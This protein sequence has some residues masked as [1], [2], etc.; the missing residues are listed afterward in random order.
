[1]NMIQKLNDATRSPTQQL[2]IIL[3]DVDMCGALV[4][5]ASDCINEMDAAAAATAAPEG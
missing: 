4:Q 3:S 2:A 5:V 1:M